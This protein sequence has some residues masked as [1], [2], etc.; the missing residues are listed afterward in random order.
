M[1]AI[2]PP[3][4]PPAP[5]EEADCTSKAGAFSKA[6]GTE[7]NAFSPMGAAHAVA[8]R[9]ITMRILSM[10]LPTR[11]QAH[12]ATQHGVW[13]G[14]AKKWLDVKHNKYTNKINTTT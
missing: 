13:S 6:G 3:A 1:L 14:W 7:G 4:M 9:A 12:M 11:Y 10:L 8:T 5:N 2:M